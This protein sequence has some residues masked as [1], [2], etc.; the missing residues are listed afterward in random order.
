MSKLIAAALM[1]I[2]AAAFAAILQTHV[3]VSHDCGFVLC[4]YPVTPGWVDPATVALLVLGAAG[5]AGVL[6]TPRRRSTPR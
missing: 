6:V 1:L 4:S 3:F 5:A 2:A